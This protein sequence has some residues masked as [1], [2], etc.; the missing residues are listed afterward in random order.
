MD[1]VLPGIERLGLADGAQILLGILV[2]HTERID[3]E[4]G[5]RRRYGPSGRQAG[6]AGDADISMAFDLQIQSRRHLGGGHDRSVAVIDR[7]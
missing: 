1:E 6:A 2:G 3:R 5:G 4:P 7:L